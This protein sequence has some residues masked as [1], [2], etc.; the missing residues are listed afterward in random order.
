MLQCESKVLP[1][2]AQLKSSPR[3]LRRRHGDELQ[4]YLCD[5]SFRRDIGIADDLSVNG[6][7]T[8]GLSS[9]FSASSSLPGHSQLC[10]ALQ[11][12]TVGSRIWYESQPLSIWS[13]TTANV[14][15]TA[16]K[17]QV[18]G[19]FETDCGGDG[20]QIT[21][22]YQGLA[23]DQLCPCRSIHRIPKLE[24][25]TKGL[26]FFRRWKNFLFHR[27]VRGMGEASNTLLE[28]HL[29]NNRGKERQI[30]NEKQ[31]NTNERS[32]EVLSDMIPVSPRGM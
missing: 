8:L 19:K 31:S 14:F 25:L 5:Q 22:P 4:I 11:I 29:A 27:D 32:S 15:S 26:A 20:G 9:L 6:R 30:T 2:E 10:N 16:L 23:Y 17:Q 12:R 28:I 24:Q 7:R 13:V 3:V 1:A 18:C 21:L